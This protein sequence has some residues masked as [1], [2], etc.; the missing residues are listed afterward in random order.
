[1]IDSGNWH[2]WI[3]SIRRMKNSAT[4]TAILTL[5]YWNFMTNVDAR[6]YSSTRICRMS[7]L[8]LRTRH[9]ITTIQICNFAIHFMNF[10]ST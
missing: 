3:K 2:Y 4:R 1:M 7:R 6:D 10:V 8:C 5:K 9:L